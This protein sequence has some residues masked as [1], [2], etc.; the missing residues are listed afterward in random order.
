MNSLAA[1]VS[2][3][4]LVIAPAGERIDHTFDR[5]TTQ[6][7]HDV[8]ATG[9]EPALTALCS[10]IAPGWI[11]PGCPVFGKV[12]NHY[13]TSNPPNGRCLR[14]EAKFGVPPLAVEYVDCP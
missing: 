14:A 5:D 3:A 8:A 11:R 10:Q 1:L 13:V 6:R 2:A 7:I 12:V 9:G 4:V